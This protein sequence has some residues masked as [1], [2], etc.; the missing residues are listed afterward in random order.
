MEDKKKRSIG[1]YIKVLKSQLP[2][3]GSPHGSTPL[4]QIKSAAN[5]YPRAC[6]GNEE[7]A[8]APNNAITCQRAWV[9]SSRRL[10]T[11]TLQRQPWTAR[12]ETWLG[13]N[14]GSRKWAAGDRRAIKQAR[15]RGAE[16]QPG[17][18]RQQPTD[19]PTGKY[20]IEKGNKHNIKN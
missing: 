17:E 2:L 7:G 1:N 14:Q 4:V 20:T 3:N 11:T 8:G 19:H 9:T 6:S 13:S 12:W 16:H 5:K 15:W 10:N 18:D